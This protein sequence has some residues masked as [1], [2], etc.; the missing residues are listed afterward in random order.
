MQSDDI[1]VEQLIAI[2]REE[3]ARMKRTQRIL[4]WAIGIVFVL[5]C[6]GAASQMFGS[7]AGMLAGAGFIAFDLFLMMLAAI[8]TVA[9]SITQ[10]HR[11]AV[12]VAAHFSDAR[13]FGYLLEAAVQGSEIGPV[14]REALLPLLNQLTPETW[15]SLSVAQQSALFKILDRENDGGLVR[16]AIGAL[17]RVGGRESVLAL[18]ALADDSPSHRQK[19]AQY[20]RIALVDIRMRLAKEIIETKSSE[21]V[22]T[23]G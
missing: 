9:V 20:A 14:A 21:S 17:K 2:L 4:R 5:V 23:L 13:T 6:T 19:T 8:V 18:E 3:N 11:W 16:S 7:A 12:S 1:D 22:V 10:R 15:H